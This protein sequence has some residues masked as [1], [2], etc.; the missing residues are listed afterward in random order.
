MSDSKKSTHLELK[1]KSKKVSK[2]Y[3][4]LDFVVV[5]R[6]NKK[7]KPVRHAK[8][9]KQIQKRGKIRKKKL[10]TLKKRIMKERVAKKSSLLVTERTVCEDSNE[11]TDRDDP[12]ESVISIAQITLESGNQEAIESKNTQGNSS[13]VDST[14]QLTHRISQ[15]SLETRPQEVI[16]S[17]TINDCPPS[18][19]TCNEPAATTTIQIN[20]SR[21][22]RE[23]C[24]H[25]ITP[26]IKKF[27]ELVLKDLFKFQENKFQLNPGE[28][29]S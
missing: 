18:D 16:E 2:V 11:I 13:V 5:K 1:R 29:C 9:S 20:H 10:S 23:Y 4:L 17:A 22:F 19:S 7:N 27:T 8:V 24:N 26:E 14:D 15:I 25:F 12:T 3:N 6:K 28:S 21:N